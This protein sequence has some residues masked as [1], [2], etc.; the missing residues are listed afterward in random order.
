MEE[1]DAL[2][3]IDAAFSAMDAD[4]RIRAVVWVNGKYGSALG[5]AE[6]RRQGQTPASE[7]DDK[8]DQKLNL[9]VGAIADL[10]GAKAADDVLRAAA[11]SLS[12]AHGRASF[13]WKD[14]LAEAG[15]ATSH[16]TKHHPSNAT[17]AA[18]R[19]RATGVLVELANGELSLTSNAKVSCF[20]Y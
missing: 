20:L 16:W 3:A 4:A 18:K 2:K 10:L 5:S 15:K 12:F 8:A 9:S 7:N 11:A 13:S 17:K 14:L 6:I 19:L 1:L